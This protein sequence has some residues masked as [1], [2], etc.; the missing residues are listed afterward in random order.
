MWKLRKILDS[1]AKKTRVV[2]F[3]LLLVGFIL[4]LSQLI[5]PMTNVHMDAYWRA[6]WAATNFNSNSWINKNA[7]PW[8]PLHPILL[9]LPL[10]IFNNPRLTPRLTTLFF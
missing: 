6:N 7:F 8:L 4:S 10:F 1:E 9:G 3:G 2:L 5:K